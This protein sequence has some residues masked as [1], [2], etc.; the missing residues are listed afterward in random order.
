M[1]KAYGRGKRT[2][3][4]FAG[5]VGLAVREIDSP[6][7]GVSSQGVREFVTRAVGAAGDAD[8]QITELQDSMLPIES[9]DSELRAGFTEVRELLGGLPGTARQF[10]R[11]LGR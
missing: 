10:L 5:R 4:A 9:G 11:T 2:Y 3:A 8:R 6:T 1:Q 7:G